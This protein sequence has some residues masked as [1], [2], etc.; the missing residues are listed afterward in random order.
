MAVASSTTQSHGRDEGNG[1]QQVGQHEG[2]TG[3]HRRK[4]PGRRKK[5]ALN[6]VPVADGVDFEE[7]Q[8]L[9]SS[10]VVSP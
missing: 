2:G 10:A 3:L 8:F 6:V 7:P 4:G 1:R 9:P 5:P